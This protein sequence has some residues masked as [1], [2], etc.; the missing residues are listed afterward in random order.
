MNSYKELW[1]ETYNKLYDLFLK[2]GFSS[3]ESDRHALLLA[4]T[5]TLDILTTRA[6]Y[7]N[8]LRKENQ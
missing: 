2:Q 5:E 3:S 6:D 4:D 8:K 7:L 1:N